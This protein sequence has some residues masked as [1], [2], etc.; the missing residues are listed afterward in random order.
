M[1][2]YFGEWLQQDDFTVSTQGLTDNQTIGGAG[3]SMGP[4]IG[5]DPDQGTS[6]ELTVSPG[7]EGNYDPGV[8]A[9]VFGSGT[10]VTD[11]R[12]G[13]GPP[14]G[15][16]QI[17]A[18][19]SHKPEL[20]SPSEDHYSASS[21]SQ[22]YA[23]HASRARF[24]APS[25]TLPP[26]ATGFQREAASTIVGAQAHVGFHHGRQDLSG[27]FSADVYGFRPNAGLTLGADTTGPTVTSWD[28][29]VAFNAAITGYD[30]DAAPVLDPNVA[31]LV[32][33]EPARSPG[34]PGT[35]QVSGTGLGETFYFHPEPVDIT[36]YL[37]GP[38]GMFV[39]ATWLR[40]AGVLWLPGGDSSVEGHVYANPVR[41]V[42]GSWGARF[43]VSYTLRPGRHR[44]IYEHAPRTPIG[45]VYPRDD[46]LG[47]SSAGRV[48]PPPTS[49]QGSGRVGPGS[50]T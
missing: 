45:R 31:G 39:Y 5:S 22:L 37:N 10:A 48:W 50:Y 30:A 12:A 11:H 42:A 17:A 49:Q 34:D 27:S 40:P 15:G 6:S 1:P 24:R 35:V 38:E 9:G 4:A 21:S 18:G 46:G 29:G 16:A 36:P 8:Y 2:E 25:P 3:I 43:D 14:L 44:F 20:F 23:V 33:A 32:Y 26:G 41:Q 13:V 28:A 7:G 47:T 19:F